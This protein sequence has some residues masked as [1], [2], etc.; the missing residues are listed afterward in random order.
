[1]CLDHPKKATDDP[2]AAQ[3]GKNLPPGAPRKG[4]PR[5]KGPLKELGWRPELARQIGADEAGLLLPARVSEV[6]RNHVHALTAQGPRRL[7]LVP[8]R[9]TSAEIAV[10]DWALADP[11][12]DQLVRLL[13]RKSLLWRR[14]A[15]E[16][17]RR[18]LIAANVDV[19]FITTALGGDFNLARLERYLALAHGAGVT[20]VIVLTRADTVDD[21]APWLAEVAQI[22]P[23]IEALAL[24]ATDPVQAGRLARWCGRG[25]TAAFVGSS[26]VGKSTL[27]AALTGQEV[28][29]GEVRAFDGRGRH[30]TTHRTLY[31]CKDGGWVIDTPG[32]RALRLTDMAEGIEAVFAELAELAAGCRFRDCRHQGEPGCAVAQ[33][34]KAGEVDPERVQRWQALL[35]EEAENRRALDKAAR[36]GS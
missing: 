2:R 23:G 7:S 36:R 12:T 20:P 30:T 3:A 34:V 13:E 5:V 1:M 9:M 4:P 26:G 19:L 11:D 14:A 21:P 29:T 28:A 8:G 10:G 16:D 35:D 27:I 15:G 32:M 22:A 6:H 25:S 18:Q 17:A 31:R 24:D 33:A